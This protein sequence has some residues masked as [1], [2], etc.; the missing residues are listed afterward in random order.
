[1][2]TE[3]NGGARGICIIMAGGRGTRFWPLSRTD[4]PKQMLPLAGENSLLH[5]TCE[6]VSGLVGPERVLVVTSA[7]LVDDVRAALPELPPANVVGEPCGRNTAPCAVLGMG[8]ASRLDPAAPVA[9]LPADHHIPDPDIFAAQLETAFVRASERRTVVTIGIRPDRPETGYGYIQAAAEADSDG[10]LQGEAFVEKPDLATAQAYLSG[11][12]HYWNGGIFVW[13]PTWFAAM[14]DLHL[15][16]VVKLMAAPVASFGTDSFAAALED[17]YAACPADSID[18]AVMEKLPGFE[19]LPARFGWSDLG[20]WDAWGALAPSPVAGVRG[21]G[22]VIAVAAKNNVV[23]VK[24]KLV[25]LVGVEDLVIVDTPDAL[26]VCRQADAQKIKDVIA[27]L[28][29]DDRQDLL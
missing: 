21:E 7:A 8:L 20:S 25:A 3:G 23:R 24:D 15:A 13:N 29:K 26:L 4:C 27:R 12:R 2:P 5:D 28:E 22:D 6:R 14:A 11:G 10:F 9:L 18:Y 19:V 1:M 17:A 16:P